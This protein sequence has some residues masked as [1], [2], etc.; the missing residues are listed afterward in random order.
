MKFLWLAIAARAASVWWPSTA[1]LV[2]GIGHLLSALKAAM[3]YPFL[4]K[5]SSSFFPPFFATR[6]LANPLAVIAFI[7]LSGDLIAG[8]QKPTADAITAP[9]RL[10][11]KLMIGA[12]AFLFFF[13]PSSLCCR[14]SGFFFMEA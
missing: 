7:F 1:G 3:L 14:N 5:I 13:L 8:S 6:P 9:R 12:I 2:F 4:G 10:R 11:Y